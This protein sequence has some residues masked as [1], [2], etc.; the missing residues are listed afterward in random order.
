MKSVVAQIWPKVRAGEVVGL[1][2]SHRPDVAH[3][4]QQRDFVYVRDA[5]DVVLWLV[6]HPAVNGIY[7]L[8]AGE[9]RTFRDLAEAAF[10]AAGRPPRIEYF[11]MPEA[12]RA[13]YQYRTQAEMTRLRS[14]GYDQP[15]TRLEEG[16]GDYISRYLAQPDAYR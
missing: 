11:D 7:N 15:L 13:A 6:E 5:M 2:K 9:A 12:I 8:G 3:G 14:A 16:V 1:F 10:R 4:G